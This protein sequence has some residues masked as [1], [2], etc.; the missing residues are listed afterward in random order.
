MIWALLGLFGTLWMIAPVALIPIVIVLSLSQKR[1]K[2]EQEETRRYLA[3]L[4]R[5]GRLTEEEYRTA[6]RSAGATWQYGY[7]PAWYHGH[8]PPPCPASPG[9]ASGAGAVEAPPRPPAPAQGSAPYGNPPYGQGQAG[10]A[11][12]WGQVTA[13]QGAAPLGGTAGSNP[14]A[15]PSWHG[16]GLPQGYRA[17]EGQRSPT[18]VPGA[19]GFVAPQPPVR[20]SMPLGTP[21]YQAIYRGNPPAPPAAHPAGAPRKPVRAA[22]VVLIVGVLFILLAGVIFATTTWRVLP[23]IARIVIIFSVSLLFFGGSALAHRRLHLRQTSL[24]FYLLGSLFLPVTILAAGH[25]ELF[26]PWLSLY[27]EGRWLLGLLGALSLGAA[28][29][30]GAGLYR[31]R[32]FGWVAL[33]CLTSAVFCAAWLFTGQFGPVSLCLALYCAVLI[34]TGG[35]LRRLG[36]KQALG[37]VSLILEQADLFALLNLAVCSF[38][39]LWGGGTY[40]SALSALLYGALFL[41]KPLNYSRLCRSG[42]G[43]YPFTL[44]LLLFLWRLGPVIPLGMTTLLLFGATAV[45]V[46]G[47]LD[48]FSAATRRALEVCSL[49]VAGAAGLSALLLRPQWSIWL[50][51]ATAVLAIAVTVQALRA[52]AL[53]CHLQPFYWLTVC[54]GGVSLLPVSGRWTPALLAGLVTLLFFAYLAPLPGGRTLRTRTSD[55]L[56]PVVTGLCWPFAFFLSPENGVAVTLL[57][58][59]QLGV[60]ARRYA[61]PRWALPHAY[62][63]GCLSATLLSGRFIEWVP[64]VWYLPLAVA[65]L[66]TLV[67]PGLS[68]LREPFCVG[69]NL[70]GSLLFLLLACSPKAFVYPVCLWVLALYWLVRL[71]RG[72]AKGREWSFWLAGAALLLAAPFTAAELFPRWG[73]ELLFIVPPGCVGVVL[74]GLYCLPRARKHPF[75]APR[76]FWLGVG[77]SQLLTMGSLLFYS[78]PHQPVLYGLLPLAC[79]LLGSLPLWREPRRPWEGPLRKLTYWLLLAMLLWGLPLGLGKLLPM[80]TYHWLLGVFLPVCMAL[81]GLYRWLPAARRSA[82]FAPRLFWT[83]AGLA[84]LLAIGTTSAY[85]ARIIPAAYGLLPLGYLLLGSIAVWREPQRPWERPLREISYWVLLPLLLCLPALALCKQFPALP[86]AWV[87]AVPLFL[88]LALLG[89][90]RWLPQAGRNAFYAPRLFWPGIILAHL[91]ALITTEVFA[92]SDGLPGYYGVLP[93]L[94]ILLSCLPLWQKRWNLS[95]FL[96]LCCL[97]RLVERVFTGGLEG[98]P[99]A[100]AVNLCLAG[101]G[102]LLALFGRCLHRRLLCRQDG[103]CLLDWLTLLAAWAPVRLLFDPLPAWRFAGCLLLAGYALLYLGRVS[104]LGDRLAWTAF[105]VSLGFAWWGQPFGALPAILAAEYGLF[106]PLAVLFSIGRWVWPARRAALGWGLFGYSV[107]GIVV[108]AMDALLHG[109]AADALFLGLIALAVLLGS[110]AL[111]QKRWFL[112]SSLT[113]IFLGLY[114]SR[115]F[116]LSLAWWAYLL[117]A[118]ILLVSLAAVSELCRQRGVKLRSRLGVFLQDW[119]W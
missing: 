2:K 106:P 90:W 38:L 114:L 43:A 110:F 112:L 86:L 102:L 100:L 10:P 94:A 91:L 108:L 58:L 9:E 107:F 25:F 1:M 60:L 82:F 23:N 116:W 49:V 50:L 78:L 44:F 3:S 95:C 8:M 14:Q 118:G 40:P 19:A 57:G 30:L 119:T 115:A 69:V 45:V 59:L 117:A 35:I 101:T 111:R 26:G 5:A 42:V 103:A 52:R 92:R 80:L 31:S 105:A 20:P 85:D 61:F 33:C 104:P 28:A 75:Y 17:P 96:P 39:S 68:R 89:L 79:L 113:L 65:A 29:V 7:P 71:L 24:A 66:A 21:A 13:A 18:A 16:D 22:N 54:W 81:L 37:R 76:L 55:I 73:S 88:A 97:Y 51:L 48:V 53:Y 99:R 98:E 70:Y 4:V 67:W 64:L 109:R 83:G 34:G 93:F 36:E 63:L 27:G 32:G 46:L 72:G 12:A 62:M 77:L 47:I 6:T 15:Y 56:L 84:L 74:L 11:T 87:L 41:T